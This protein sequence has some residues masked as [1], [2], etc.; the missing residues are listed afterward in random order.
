MSYDL[1]LGRLCD[2]IICGE[3]VLPTADSKVKNELSSSISG[4]K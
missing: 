4:S 3:I 2:T 1:L